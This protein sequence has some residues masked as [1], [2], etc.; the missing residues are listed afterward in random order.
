MYRG[1]TTSSA[2]RDDR[3][4]CRR[5]VTVRAVR[6]SD[7]LS[8]DGALDERVY[9]D[10]LPAGGFI[11]TEPS[12]G[13]PA[14]QQTDV[15][16]LFDDN[17]LYISARCWDSAPESE[18]VA[19]EMRRDNFGIF[20]NDSLGILLDTFYDRRNGVEFL[21]NH[22]RRPDGWT[23]HRRAPVQRRLEP[24]LGDSGGTFRRRLDR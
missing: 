14:T 6:V 7:P 4:R 16:V 17:N 2:P 10:I 9:R 24:D 23:G 15:W 13:T 11:Q 8:I 3:P 12:A 19:N 22:D 18:W 5:G 21:V 20:R 1:T